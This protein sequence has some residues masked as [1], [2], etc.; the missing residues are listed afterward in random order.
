MIERTAAT[1]T[2]ADSGAKPE[3]LKYE[4]SKKRM[5]RADRSDANN[6]KGE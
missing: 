4:K 3:I 1:T 6:E 2:S 5:P